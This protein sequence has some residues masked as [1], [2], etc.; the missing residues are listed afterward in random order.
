MANCSISES[1]AD[2][3]RFG[4]RREINGFRVLSEAHVIAALSSMQDQF[5]MLI[6]FHVGL[7]V[8]AARS[9]AGMRTMEM[10]HTLR[11]DAC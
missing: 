1:P 9:R 10:R 7:G 3:R 11:Q 6:L 4:K 2:G 5:A 8:V